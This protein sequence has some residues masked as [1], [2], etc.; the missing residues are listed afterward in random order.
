MFMSKGKGTQG[1]GK[2]RHHQWTETMEHAIPGPWWQRVRLDRP[3]TPWQEELSDL[4]RQYIGNTQS[5]KGYAEEWQVY[6]NR[7]WS[8]F[9]WR[10]DFEYEYY[11]RMFQGEQG[12]NEQRSEQ[13]V[14]MQRGRIE[15]ESLL[16]DKIR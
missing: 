13:G 14:Q 6:I 4:Y 10:E 9:I 1:Q 5:W 8:H 16:V 11:G 3:S 2:H 15:W 12:R 7:K